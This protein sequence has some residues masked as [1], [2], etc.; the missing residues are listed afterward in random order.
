[1]KPTNEQEI[2]KYRFVTILFLAV[3]AI[4]LSTAIWM[5]CINAKPSIFIHLLI[6]SMGGLVFVMGLLQWLGFSKGRVF[7]KE[8]RAIS[9]RTG[10]FAFDEPPCPYRVWIFCDVPFSRYYGSICVAKTSGRES[11]IIKVPNR[12]RWLL[13]WWRPRADVS[14]ITWKSEGRTDA[15]SRCSIKFD[16]KPA[17]TGSVF[18][19]MYPTHDVESVTI[20]IKSFGGMA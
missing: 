15:Q 6:G 7:F 1:M 2:Q 11:Q 20:L 4:L 8:K 13:W 12:S 14:P 5:L 18:D 9:L 19:E 16:L 17:F 10:E 3:G